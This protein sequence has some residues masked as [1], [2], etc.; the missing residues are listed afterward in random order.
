MKRN[1]ATCEMSPLQEFRCKAI[2]NPA[3]KNGM[4]LLS[5]PQRRKSTAVATSKLP[6]KATPVRKKT[7]KRS[8]KK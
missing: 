3:I 2:L 8:K 1:S 7:A 4:G 6:A 5:A